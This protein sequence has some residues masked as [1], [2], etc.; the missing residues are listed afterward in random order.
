M[1][2]DVAGIINCP[3]NKNLLNKSKIGVTEYFAT[4]CAVNDN[5]EVMLIKN[6]KLMVSPLTTHL[7]IKSIP[8][9]L[10]Q[11]LIIK[12]IKVIDIWYKKEFNKK[13]KIA[14]LGLNHIMELKNHE[15]NYTCN[16]NLK[17]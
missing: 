13:A 12:K 6:K 10:T 1:L 7:D 5:S 15:N 9:K 3:I 17:M 2:K 8:R 11:K 4:K 14:I 16:K